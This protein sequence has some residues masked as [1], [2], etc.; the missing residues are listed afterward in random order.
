MNCP[1]CKYQW[2][3]ITNNPKVCP[4]CKARLDYGKWETQTP[5][6]PG[7]PPIQDQETSEAGK[8]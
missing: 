8:K 2:K 6:E 7:T 4:R 5:Q 3:P 1:K